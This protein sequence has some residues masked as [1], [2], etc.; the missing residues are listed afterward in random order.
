MCINVADMVL[1]DFALL[2][3]PDDS[4]LWIETC[5]NIQCDV[6]Q[7][8]QALYCAVC[9]LNVAEGGGGRG[10]MLSIPTTRFFNL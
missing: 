7:I 4:L 6:I 9:W 8:S 3:S 5:R 2:W 1:C 10:T